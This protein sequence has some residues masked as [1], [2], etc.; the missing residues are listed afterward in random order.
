MPTVSVG[1]Y[2]ADFKSRFKLLINKKTQIAK[3]DSESDLAICG[4]VG[5]SVG[6]VPAAE[7]VGLMDH[8]PRV[9]LPL[10][11]YHLLSI[12]LQ[13]S[14][15]LPQMPLQC[16]ESMLLHS[17]VHKCLSINETVQCIG[18]L[19]KKPQL[20]QREA[21]F[22]LYGSVRSSSQNRASKYRK[23][24]PAWDGSVFFGPTDKL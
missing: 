11:Y 1:I 19:R 23:G 4:C 13:L 9:H 22:A 8:L 14:L 16:V 20:Q 17:P 7:K 24:L 21:S 15:A 10:W 6:C 18:Q 5:S 2:S 12:S 3:S